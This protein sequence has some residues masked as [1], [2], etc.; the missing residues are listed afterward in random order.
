MHVLRFIYAGGA[1]AIL[2]NLYIPASAQALTLTVASITSVGR[3]MSGTC[4]TIHTPVIGAGTRATRILA[5]VASSRTCGAPIKIRVGVI[6]ARQYVLILTGCTS[7]GTARLALAGCAAV[8][9][10][11]ARTL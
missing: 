11:V 2:M 9:K 8:R 7:N 6:F 1:D 10:R 4:L 5:R 3:Q